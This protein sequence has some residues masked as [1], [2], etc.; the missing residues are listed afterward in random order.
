[1]HA[2]ITQPVGVQSPQATRPREGARDIT[3]K[4]LWLFPAAVTVHNLEEMFTLPAW[5]QTAGRLHEPVGA[6][7]FGLAVAVLTALAWAVTSRAVREGSQSPSMYVAL[8]Y[9][10]AMLLNVF[11]PHLM[12]TLI[13]GQYTPGII[14][15]VAINLPVL[16]YLLYRAFREGQVSFGRYALITPAVCFS[17]VGL[18]QVLFALGRLI[19]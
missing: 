5:S 8:G 4:A 15:A 11:V 14:T 7:P 16:G 1:M 9:V 6:F 3:A 13:T 10:T 17:L 19:G 18:L 12:S 2:D